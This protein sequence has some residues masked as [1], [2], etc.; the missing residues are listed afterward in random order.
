MRGYT[1]EKLEHLSLVVGSLARQPVLTYLL[2]ETHLPAGSMLL[3]A[4]VDYVVQQVPSP[5]A[6]SHQSHALLLH[7]A[8]TVLWQH[9]GHTVAAV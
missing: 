3:G 5:S 1:M 7:P 4:P 9:L 8:A 2:Q 6:A